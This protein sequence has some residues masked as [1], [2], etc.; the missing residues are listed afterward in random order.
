MTNL[1]EEFLYTNSLAIR[2][3]ELKTNEYTRN[4]K[5]IHFTKWPDHGVPPI[6]K[7][8]DAF[9]KI[10]EE[11]DNNEDISKISDN[12]YKSPVVVHCSAG[13]GRTGTFIS[14]YNF[15]SILK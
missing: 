11:V 2:S 1:D 10:I 4:V 14:L 5:Q 15:H 13:V 12:Q 3:L 8:Y 9:C 6:D 7:V